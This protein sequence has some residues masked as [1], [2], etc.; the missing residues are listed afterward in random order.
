[1]SAVRERRTSSD[2]E[3]FSDAI[4]FRSTAAA[5]LQTSSGVTMED[6]LNRL[7]LL[8]NAFAEIRA[9]LVTLATRTDL[10][11]LRAELK[12]D[13]FRLRAEMHARDVTMIKW[14]VGT[15]FTTSAAAFSAARFIH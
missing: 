2:A 1:M 7:R 3:C 9:Q 4:C 11:T 6:I 15:A 13:I 14:M 5:S 12:E 8:E 10:A